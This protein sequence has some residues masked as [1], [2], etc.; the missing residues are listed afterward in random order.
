MILTSL[1]V[2]GAKGT[3]QCIYRT[4]WILVLLFIFPDAANEPTL[5]DNTNLRQ[6]VLVPLVIKSVCS[7]IGYSYG[8]FCF[9]NVDYLCNCLEQGGIASSYWHRGLQWFLFLHASC[10]EL[11]HHISW[12]WEPNSTKL[13]LLFWSSSWINLSFCYIYLFK[14][15]KSSLMSRF[16][17]PIAY[18]GRAS[19]I[20]I[21]GTDVIRPRLLLLFFFLSFPFNTFF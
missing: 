12:T 7:C 14:F 19:S 17:L 8:D 13:V 6:K 20:V 15:R 5:R 9:S 1:L 21:S 10:K 4:R 3:F 11:R 2:C 16:H 18:H